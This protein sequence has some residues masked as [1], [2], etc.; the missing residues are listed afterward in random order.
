MDHFIQKSSIQTQI[1]VST[2]YIYYLKC[3]CYCYVS[4]EIVITSSYVKLVLYYSSEKK[5]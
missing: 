1:T 4:Q 3:P 2:L 5:V